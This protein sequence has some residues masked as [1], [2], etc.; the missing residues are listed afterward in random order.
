MKAE[1]VVV[2]LLKLNGSR[3]KY[4]TRFQREVFLLDCCCRTQFNFSFSYHDCS[5]HSSELVDGWIDARD[6]KRIEIEKEA[7]LYGVSHMIFKLTSQEKKRDDPERL[8]SLKAK[9]ARQKLEEM[10][11]TPDV[12]LELAADIA[13]LEN[14]EGY[15]REEAMVELKIRK[16]FTARDEGAKKKALDLLEALREPVEEAVQQEPATQAA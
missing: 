13:Y 9:K 7:G 3:L 12:V 6:K 14:N 5:P 8:G 15:S 2:N 11:N 1:N 4:R 16:P 10:A